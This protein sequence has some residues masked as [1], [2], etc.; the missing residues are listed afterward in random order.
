VALT[1][2]RTRINFGGGYIRVRDSIIPDSSG[3]LTNRESAVE[4][5]P[6][7]LEIKLSPTAGGYLR[8]LSTIRRV[9]AFAELIYRKGF[10]YMGRSV[11]D[12]Y[13][14]NAGVSYSITEDLSIR[15]K[16]ENLLNR[17]IKIPYLALQTGNVM[18]Y[19]VRERTLYLSVDWVF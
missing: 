17:A 18:A 5:R 19:P 1:F 7:S 9:S 16:G 6:V 3:I 15:L 14:L 8:L 12:G 2:G 13:D 4:Y 10:T 11:E